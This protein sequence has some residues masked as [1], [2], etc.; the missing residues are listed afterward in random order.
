MEIEDAIHQ[1]EDGIRRLK[2]QYELFF[3]GA[4]PRPP[5]ELRAQVE[6]VIRSFANASIRRYSDRFLFNTLVGRYNSFVELWNKQQRVL[7]EGRDRPG[8]PH[9]FAGR[10][11]AEPVTEAPAGNATN[12]SRAGVARATADAVAAPAL[13]AAEASTLCTVRL[14][15][16]GNGAEMATLFENYME[17]RRQKTGVVPKLTLDSFARQINQQAEALRSSTG[18]ESVEFRL[19]AADSQV[20]IKARPASAAALKDSSA[21]RG[22]DDDGGTEPFGGPRPAGRTTP[23]G[24]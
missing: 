4:S 24:R 12:G 1:L 22:G 17:A 10:P 3:S 11:G 7:D 13:A 5:V 19:T 6:K 23:R 20:T 8:L 14:A 2:V 15:A 9:M 21:P 16:G 18:C